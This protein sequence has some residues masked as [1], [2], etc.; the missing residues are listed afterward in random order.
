MSCSA[1]DTG[2]GSWTLNRPWVSTI[3]GWSTTAATFNGLI[4]HNAGD[5]LD[6][7]INAA[8]LTVVDHFSPDTF[9]KLPE[10]KFAERY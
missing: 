6:A 5:K 4:V 1:D 10:A 2:E 7:A 9:E 8:S 3:C